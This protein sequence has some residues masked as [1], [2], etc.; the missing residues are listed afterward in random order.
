MPIYGDKLTSTQ[1][2]VVKNIS[3]QEFRKLLKTFKQF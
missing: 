1:Y 2:K 3:A